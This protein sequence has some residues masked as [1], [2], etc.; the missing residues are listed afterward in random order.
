V[1]CERS[2]SGWIERFKVGD[3]TVERKR[4]VIRGLWERELAP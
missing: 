1:S 4:G 3:R 2:V